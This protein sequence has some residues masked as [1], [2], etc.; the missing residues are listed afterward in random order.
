MLLCAGC[1]ENGKIVFGSSMDLS[2]PIAFDGKKYSQGL[3]VA[4]IELEVCLGD[5]MYP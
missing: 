3:Q 1:G 4:L 5:T 2:G